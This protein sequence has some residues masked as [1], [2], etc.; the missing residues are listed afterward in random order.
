MNVSELIEE[1]KKCNPNAMVIVSGYEGGV[2]E[3]NSVNNTTI[4]LNQNDEWYYGK[5]ELCEDGEE[6]VEAVHL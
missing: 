2:D 6:G 5:H 3:V 4:K 1:L